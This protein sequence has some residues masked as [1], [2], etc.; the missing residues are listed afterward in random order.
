MKKKIKILFSGAGGSG[1]TGIINGLRA[2]DR[3][4][5]AA[6]DADRYSAGLYLADY[7]EVVPLVTQKSYFQR[8]KR[9][10]D[11][12]KIDVYMP[13]I[14]EELLPAYDFVKGCPGLALLLPRREFTGLVLNKYKMV[15]AFQQAGIRC[16][17]T[18]L[19]G[20]ITDAV[21]KKRMFLKPISGRG[22]RGIAVINSR[23]EYEQYFAGQTVYGRSEV[24]L[25]EYI[26]G[27]EYT[28]SAVIGQE[29]WVYA[30]VPK[31]II[32]KQGITHLSVTENNKLIEAVVRQI[33]DKFRADGPFNVQLKIFRGKPYILEV[34]PRFSTT[35]VHTIAAG[36][37]E[38]DCIVRDFLGIY[39]EGKY[40][41]FKS[42]LVMLRHFTQHFVPRG[43]LK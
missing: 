14:D 30:V 12:F 17:A 3:Y 19:H 9:L 22:S 16:P 27:D 21:F 1:A 20:E 13:L 38:I 33:Q 28:V 29:G 8:I 31:K 41:H 39:D 43:A 34:N 37:N 32:K 23:R 26:G 15:K 6:V 7:G 35:V 36:V 40:L 25:Q 4:W 11:R 5:I 24:M 10:V 42:D 2:T 18:F